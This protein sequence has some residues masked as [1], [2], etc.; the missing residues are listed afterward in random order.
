MEGPRE[1]A[2]RRKGGYEGLRTVR[3]PRSWV[4]DMMARVP[5]SSTPVLHA[6]R[7]IIFLRR[8]PVYTHRWRGWTLPSCVHI[9]PPPSTLPLAF[10]FPSFTRNLNP[11]PTIAVAR[12]H[13]H[14]SPLFPKQGTL[15]HFESHNDFPPVLYPSLI[16]AG[17]CFCDIAIREQM[18]T[19][20]NIHH[21]PSCLLSQF[22]VSTWACFLRSCF[23][24]ESNA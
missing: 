17:F 16:P 9:S 8:C 13:T 18:G 15:L 7:Y 21:A 2:E 19:V 12:T 4:T 24:G 22:C 3:P 10:G 14:H 5:F 20:L 11:H 23:L 6:I 1:E